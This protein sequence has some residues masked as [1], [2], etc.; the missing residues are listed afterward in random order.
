MKKVVLVDGNNLLFRGYYATSHNDGFMR[1]KDGFPTN[2]IYSLVNM[3]NKV[4]IEEKPEYIMVAFDVGKTFRHEKFKDYKGERAKTP[5]ELLQQFPVAKE[6]LTYMGIKYVECDGYEADDIIGTYSKI[7][8][9]TSDMEAVIISSDKDLLQLISD[10]VVVKQLKTKDYI[11]MN[12]DTFIDKYGIEPIR[13]IDLKSLMGD[14]SDNIKGVRGIGEVGALKLL[15]E[16]QTLDNIYKNIDNISGANREKLINGKEDAYLSYELATIYRDVPIDNNLEIIKYKGADIENLSLIYKKLEFYSL[17]KKLEGSTLNERR[18]DDIPTTVIGSL[19]DIKIDSKCSLY[20]ESDNTNYH[21]ANI[22]YI[23]IYNNKC[24]YVYKGDNLEGLENII[25]YIDVVYDYKKVYVLLYK[26]GIVLPENVFDISLAAYLLNYNVKDD[27][28]VLANS[29]DYN[30]PLSLT[31]SKFSDEEIISIISDKASFIYKAKDGIMES[32]KDKGVNDLYND[33]E[34]PLSKVLAGMELEGIRVDA[35]VL[36]GMKSEI[37]AKLESLANNVY[38]LAGCEFNLSSPKQVG[39]VL[40]DKLGLPHGKK[41]KSGYVTDISV[42]SKLS[43]DYEIV[44]LILEHRMLSKLYS[45]YIEGLSNLISAD[46]KIHTIYTQT[47]TRTGRLSSVEPNLQNIP[48]RSEYGKLIRKAFVAEEDS[49]ILSSD[50][51]QIEL[52]VFTHFAGVEALINAFKSDMDIHTKTAEDIF[53]ITKEEVD[54]SK[55]RLAKAVNFGILYGISSYGLSEDLGISISEAKDFMKRYF[56]T[57]PGIKE[58]MNKEIEEAYNLGYVKTIMNRKRIITELSS[59]NRMIRSMGERMALNTKV[60]G[61]AADILKI[62]MINIDKR[63]KE[64]NIK[65]KMLLQVH[66]EL[67]FNVLNSEREKVTSIIKDEMENVYKLNVPLKVD[68]NYGKN[69][70]EAK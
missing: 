39:E 31:K 29:M 28:A 8:D 56:E 63:F 53:G 58:Y 13:M 3:I 16:Y 9:N 68:I 26:R 66:D 70:Y 41:N 67:I 18:K 2:A 22:T 14:P 12:R 33:I 27:V 6:V 35:S 15:K 7:V 10:K 60:Q 62:A 55:R 21:K 17:L 46:G 48:I 57:Y 51:S 44:R 34:A 23:G 32:L 65:S 38:N 11:L 42:L 19:K 45:T 37:S 59:S 43:D 54:A 61:S 36:N 40:F 50:Y 25:P 1:T 5:E 30:I 64:D 20:I 69:W 47:L 24:N 52:R 49:V 4:L